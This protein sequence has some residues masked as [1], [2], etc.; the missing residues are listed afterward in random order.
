MSDASPTH[1]GL[2]HAIFLERAA[3]LDS[4]TQSRFGQAAFLVLR[5]VDLLV[6]TP[7]AVTSRNLF[8]YQAAATGRYCR[9]Q[10][11]AGAEGEHLLSVVS[12]AS[13]AHHGRDQG[14]LAPAMLAYADFLE[15][16][17]RY[18]EALDV[19]DTL[20]RVGGARLESALAVRA[21]L[22]TGRINREIA[23]FDRADAA[24]ERAAALAT[25]AGDRHSALLSR[26]GRA[27]AFRGRGNL[28][29]A[30]RWNREVL[31]QSE[32][33]ADR[34][35][36]ARAAHGLG[37]VLGTRGQVPDAIPLLW[38]AF[39]VQVDETLSYQ[40]L[41]DLGFALARLGLIEEAELA[42]KYVAKNCR[43]QSTVQN[44]LIELMHCS[45]YRR[46]YFGFK[47]WRSCCEEVRA[48]MAPNIITDYHLKVGIGLARFGKLTRAL[49]ELEHALRI[50]QANG[51]HE[52]EFR[53]ERIRAGLRDCEVLETAECDA[54][55]EPV[56]QRPALTKVSAALATL[57]D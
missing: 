38:R 16:G 8:R 7:P 28:A 12:G 40:A 56:A 45:S 34:D 46:D 24:Y 11:P 15:A 20:E 3:E 52:F 43:T 55:A 29:E 2:L 6:A 31:A 23:R 27:N 13:D 22:S 10:V 32:T 19:L 33:L 42:F 30:E 36:E 1:G 4:P 49:P 51:L 26:L 17:A 37:M 48:L 25:A 18:E 21:A 44:A 47:R 5:L 9:E 14:L 53:I 54:V 57:A 35:A 39:S 41:H 50:A